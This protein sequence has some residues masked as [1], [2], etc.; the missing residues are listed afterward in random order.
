MYPA[1]ID[2]GASVFGKWRS[3]VSAGLDDVE[4]WLELLACAVELASFFSGLASC[5]EPESESDFERPVF[6]EVDELLDS[7]ARLGLY[8]PPY[9][10][11]G[12]MLSRC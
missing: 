6:D 9:S 12:G 3:G 11:G 10:G 4:A 5:A 7:R 8:E 2:P 1:G